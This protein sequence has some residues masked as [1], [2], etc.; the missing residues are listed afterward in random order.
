MTNCGFLLTLEPETV[1]LFHLLG[2]SSPC[3]VSD[4]E[5]EESVGGPKSPVV[6]NHQNLI[7]KEILT[8]FTEKILKFTIHFIIPIREAV[9]GLGM[10]SPP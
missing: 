4:Q 1:D 2:G 3:N 8:S 6:A 5:P 9:P 7:N 10:H